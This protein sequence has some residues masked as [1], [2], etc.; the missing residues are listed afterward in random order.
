MEQTKMFLFLGLL[1]ASLFI[2]IVDV[3]VST[4][5]LAP[6]IKIIIL[7]IALFLDTLAISSRF[8]SYLIFP[9]FK[10]MKRHVVLSKEDPYWIASS[11]D[12][13]LHKEGDNYIATVYIKIPLYRSE[14]E[15]NVDE[16]LEFAT[17]TSRLL[18]QSRMPIR[19]THEMR[20]IN[21]DAYI[22][23]IKNMIAD[24]ENEESKLLEQNSTASELAKVRGKLSMWRGMMDV[25]NS[26]SSLEL[27]T[28]ASVSATGSQEFE[29]IG[30][31]QQRAREVISAVSAIFGITSSIVT[32]NDLLKFVEPEYMIPYSTISEKIIK[33][34]N[35]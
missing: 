2:L 5:I 17:Q 35:V 11:L 4:V 26:S 19:F 3:S 6:P 30:I 20:I 32:G 7:L 34:I 13:I 14:T 9:M 12:S 29:A 24:A 28:Y 8:Y 27:L 25:L 21:K 31:V 18:G 23:T 22:E 16:K 33:T 10:Q 15:M 1:G